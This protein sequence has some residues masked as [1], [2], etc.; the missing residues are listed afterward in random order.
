M[1]RFFLLPSF[2]LLLVAYLHQQ[3]GQQD[4]GG[5][6]EGDDRV[7]ALLHQLG[8]LPPLVLG[9]LVQR[10]PV[11]PRQIKRARKGIRPAKGK[12]KKKR[13]KFSLIF[14]FLFF[15]LVS[16]P[17]EQLLRGQEEQERDER[18]GQEDG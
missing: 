3:Q 9:E 6:D 15:L 2:C 17:E 8:H 1:V 14:F 5:G 13:K 10:R 12:G 11:A 4:V 18:L 16:R 7:R